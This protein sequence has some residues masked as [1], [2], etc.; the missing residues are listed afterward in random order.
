M[1]QKMRHVHALL[2]V[3]G[4]G[5]A[6]AQPIQIFDLAAVAPALD[7]GSADGFESGDTGARSG[8]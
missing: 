6:A 2:V 8:P 5:L 1:R 7:G 4:P 3:L